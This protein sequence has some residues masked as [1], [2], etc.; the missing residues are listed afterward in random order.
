MI[1]SYQKN[2]D[3]N[4]GTCYTQKIKIDKWIA[5]EFNNYL[6]NKKMEIDKHYFKTRLYS[7][8]DL[9]IKSIDYIWRGVNYTNL[10]HLQVFIELINKLNNKGYNFNTKRILDRNTII[11]VV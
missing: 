7:E 9:K 1:I 11:E 6:M 8:Y 2:W 5:E 10:I 4:T 3:N